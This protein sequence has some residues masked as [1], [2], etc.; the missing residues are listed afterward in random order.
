MD[1]SA[2]LPPDDPAPPDPV[3]HPAA[4]D[5]AA[6]LRFTNLMATITQES[7]LDTRAAV[8]A[9]TELL[10]ERGLID[11]AEFKDRRAGIHEMLAEQHKHY[12]V[13]VLI[14]DYPDKYQAQGETVE[15]DCAAR[16]HLCKGSCC[17]LRFML[18]RQDLDEGIV[19][20]EYHRPYLNAQRA[21]GYCTHNDSQTLRCTIYTHRPTPCRVFD[22]RED[23]RIWVDFAARIPN[24][25]LASLPWSPPPTTEPPGLTAGPPVGYDTGN[26]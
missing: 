16:Y 8:M 17:R 12:G 22:C 9:L 13:R 26:G 25:T 24:P 10:L 18:T 11:M 6:G 5:V 20:W 7:G 2:P 15:I 3:L 21:D 23:P 14:G 4:D 1:I 19:R